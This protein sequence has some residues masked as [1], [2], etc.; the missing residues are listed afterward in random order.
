MEMDWNPKI[1]IGKRYLELGFKS[2]PH[3]KSMDPSPPHCPRSPPEAS[4]SEAELGYAKMSELIGVSHF[5]LS[6]VI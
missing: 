4:V 3:P 2:S 6:E 5:D 1:F